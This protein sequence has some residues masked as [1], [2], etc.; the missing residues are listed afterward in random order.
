[1]TH[2]I[3]DFEAE[4]PKEGPPKQEK[5]PPHYLRYSIDCW[6]IKDLAF[7]ANIIVEYLFSMAQTS[8]K[9]FPPTTISKAKE[10]KLESTFHSFEFA[11]TKE[12]LSPM[13]SKCSLTIN[14]YHSER[15]D[16]STLIGFAIVS[17]ACVINGLLTQTPTSSAR[18]F[19]SYYPIDFENK[20]I[21]EA[22]I[23]LYLEDLGISKE[24]VTPAI[25]AENTVKYEQ[26][27][28][29]ELEYQY[30]WEL[31]AWK[32]SE[33]AQFKSYLKDKES[34]LISSLNEQ[35]KIKEAERDKQL[36]E[37]LSK[38]NS[39]ATKIKKSANDLQ[40]REQKLSK[41]EDELKQK[42]TEVGRQQVIKEEEILATKQN[43][44]DERLKLEKEKKDLHIQ[45]DKLCSQVAEL[46]ATLETQ[47]KEYQGSPINMLRQEITAKGIEIIELQ[48]QLEKASQVK[49][50]YKL[51]YEKMK[52]ELIKM[53]K[54]L[55]EEKENALKR[56]L[57]EYE[58]VSLQANSQKMA[59]EEQKE[60][61]QLKEMII[62]LQNRLSG[63]ASGKQIMKSAE[64]IQTYV[65]ATP[66]QL[67][68]TKEDA[69]GVSDL[70]RLINEKNELLSTGLYNEEDELIKELSKQIEACKQ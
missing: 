15:A 62:K 54:L 59:S 37:I 2:Y 46:K 60:I 56:K 38:I 1:M 11:A 49:D 41:L 13:L 64:N 22:R 63:E 69:K 39:N 34:E 57:E 12:E 70:E 18:T 45:N 67:S 24:K 19:D 27:N 48:R 53:K 43:S 16:S 10:T 6:S 5:P 8:L 29:K 58:R 4:T 65:T 44:K 51:Q 61:A 3:E 31:D 26:T 7:D 68:N 36:Q 30:V 47:Q 9:S 21:G 28:L 14:F 66:M 23:I 52:I 35:S 42:I 17:P 20:K 32:N 40:L 25:I 33:Q 50:Q 55:D